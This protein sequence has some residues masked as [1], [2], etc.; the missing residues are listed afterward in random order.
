MSRSFTRVDVFCDMS[1]GHISLTASTMNRLRFLSLQKAGGNTD[2]ND[3]VFHIHN[4]PV[5]D[6][7]KPKDMPEILW[8][9]ENIMGMRQIVRSCFMYGVD[10]DL[11]KMGIQKLT[12]KIKETTG[13]SNDEAFEVAT[14]MMEFKHRPSTHVMWIANSKSP[15]FV[16]S[17][18]RMSNKHVQKVIDEFQGSGKIPNLICLEECPENYEHDI[19]FGNTIADIHHVDSQGNIRS[20]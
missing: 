11:Q 20:I 14:E 3:V 8:V 13:K 2:D 7:M 9:M 15:S 1:D 17:Y 10:K 5:R 18:V 12:E 16:Q 6:S 19:W 4:F